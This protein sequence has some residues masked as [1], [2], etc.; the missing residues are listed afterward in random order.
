MNPILGKPWRNVM[1]TAHYVVNNNEWN[2]FSFSLCFDIIILQDNP[3]C[4]NVINKLGQ[5]YGS[6]FLPLS[7]K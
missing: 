3:I 4:I 6:P 7:K 1:F 5:K 2:I